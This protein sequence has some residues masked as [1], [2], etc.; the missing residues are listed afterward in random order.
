MVHYNIPIRASPHGES[1]GLLGNTM[2]L[3]RDFTKP[4]RGRIRDKISSPT[5]AA[6]VAWDE[7]FCKSPCVAAFVCAGVRA[8]KSNQDHGLDRDAD[9]RRRRSKDT[10]GVDLADMIESG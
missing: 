6:R 9:K 5:K 4:Q 7:G 1:V 2:G 10:Q 3:M 8:A